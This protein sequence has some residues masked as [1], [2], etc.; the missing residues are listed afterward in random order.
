MT[1]QR[2]RRFTFGLPN[3]NMTTGTTLATPYNQL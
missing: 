2:D 3:G 1:W